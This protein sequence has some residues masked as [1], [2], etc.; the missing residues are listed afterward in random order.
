LLGL[1]T[2]AAADNGGSNEDKADVAEME[3][4]NHQEG[5][6]GSDAPLHGPGSREFSAR[7]IPF[8][9]TVQW[10]R[11]QCQWN[12]AVVYAYLQFD[13]RRRPPVVRSGE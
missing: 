8:P 4:Q 5:D 13:Q 12:Q 2:P 6:D 9:S 7:S 1:L 10:R 11:G 3:R